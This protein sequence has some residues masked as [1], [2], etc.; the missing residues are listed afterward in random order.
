MMAEKGSLKSKKQN[1]RRSKSRMKSIK[2]WFDTVDYCSSRVFRIFLRGFVVFLI[3]SQKLD[4]LQ[5]LIPVL[6]V[7]FGKIFSWLF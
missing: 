2:G 4:V 5:L 6:P 7:D 3:I 1:E